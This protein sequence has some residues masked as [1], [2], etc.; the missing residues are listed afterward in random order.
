VL[1]TFCGLLHRRIAS[2]L[3]KSL[4]V[5]LKQKKHFFLP[6]PQTAMSLKAVRLQISLATFCTTKNP[7]QSIFY[8]RL[9]KKI[10][11]AF[12][13]YLEISKILVFRT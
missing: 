10:L 7:L 8:N 6:H 9:Q 4:Q 13:I 11:G 3:K 1:A 5:S 2:P 12:S